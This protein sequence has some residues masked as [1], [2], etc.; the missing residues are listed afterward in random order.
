MPGKTTRITGNKKTTAK[1]KPTKE[2]RKKGKGSKTLTAALNTY[3]SVKLKILPGKSKNKKQSENIEDIPVRKRFEMIV[4]NVRPP[5]RTIGKNLDALSIDEKLDTP[6]NKKYGYVNHK[7]D[8]IDSNFLNKEKLLSDVV[9]SAKA[10]RKKDNTFLYIIIAL[11]AA[12]VIYRM[13]AKK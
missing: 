6:G 11:V 12:F 1:I 2:K 5:E 4:D 3:K 13:T 9:V 10:K 8:A 7:D